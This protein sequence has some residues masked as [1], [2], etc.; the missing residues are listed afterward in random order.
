M[1]RLTAYR[2]LEVSA[3]RFE[4]ARRF[5]PT[6]DNGKS[7]IDTIRLQYDRDLSERLSFDGAA[8]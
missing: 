1:D 6:G 3:W 2:K 4:I 8:R 5:Q 7:T